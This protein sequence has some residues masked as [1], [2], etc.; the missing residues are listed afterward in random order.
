MSVLMHDEIKLFRSLTED[1]CYE[2]HNTIVLESG[3][4]SRKKVKSK[5]KVYQSL[6]VHEKAGAYKWTFSWLLFLKF[7]ALL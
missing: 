7:F 4:D 1:K 3:N 6:H 5:R 2:T